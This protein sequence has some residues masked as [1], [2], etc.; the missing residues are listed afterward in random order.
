[1]F[2][3][4]KDLAWNTGKKFQK[5]NCSQLAASITYYVIFSTFPVLIF[6]AGFIGLVLSESDQRQV[7]EEALKVIPLSQTD[8]ATTVDNAVDSISG[9]KAPFIALVGLAGTAWGASGM[10]TAIRR[11]LNIVYREPEYS[12]PWV[13]QKL[14]DLAF[15]LGIGVFFTAS[16]A[17]STTL[18]VTNTSD[19]ALD[20]VGWVLAEYVGP[21][22]LSF[23][24]FIVLYTIVPSRNRNLGNA[25]PGALV[26][27][28]L[29]EIVKFG[30]SFY[31]S[32]FKNFD[33]VFGS[34]GALATFM[35][36][37]YLSSQIMLL[38]AEVATVYP[39]VQPQGYKQ[40]KF[41]GFGV[42]F[43]TKVYRAVRKLFVREEPKLTDKE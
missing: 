4:L 36:W 37:V 33:V 23:V 30:F 43:T 29:F 15:V 42:P 1:V 10:F 31:V 34:L 40:A 24:A 20:R 12:R 32:N 9:G 17:V 26:A 11:G 25:W 6:I 22:V 41:G 28:L 18:R 39:T 35:F 5:D 7:I 8:A 27:A 21:F 2:K 13:Q 38:G 3:F 16:I 19:G 14:I